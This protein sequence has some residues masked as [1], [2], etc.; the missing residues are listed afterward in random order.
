MG[1]ELGWT[2]ENGRLH[3]EDA[4]FSVCL[5]VLFASASCASIL[6]GVGGFGH[7]LR[8]HIAPE[9]NENAYMSIHIFYSTFY[10]PFLH[11]VV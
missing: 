11:R 3:L 1:K 9:S 6:L 7:A 2:W 10:A 8:S 5:S 4:A